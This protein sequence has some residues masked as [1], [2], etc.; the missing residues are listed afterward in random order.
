M[1][2]L[3]E[4]QGPMIKQW[5]IGSAIAHLR[6]SVSR[7]DVEQEDTARLVVASDM[8][9]ARKLARGARIA[10]RSIL[11]LNNVPE[12]V[13]MEVS[14]TH[15]ESETV[16]TR[17]VARIP[18]LEQDQ[19]FPPS[20]GPVSSMTNSSLPSM[21]SLPEARVPIIARDQG[22][23]ESSKDNIEDSS[24]LQDI[25]TDIWNSALFQETKS[26]A[27]SSFTVSQNFE[28][29][30]IF[31]TITTDETISEWP[32][33]VQAHSGRKEV[34]NTGEVADASFTVSQNIE[35]ERIFR[36][37]RNTEEVAI[38]TTEKFLDESSSRKTDTKVSDL[39]LD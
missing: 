17:F 27:P 9:E 8:V 13:F 39:D 32:Q 25:F 38:S 18:P 14:P 2:S 1:T 4:S 36:E 22:W 28:L 7:L 30:G 34:R 21:S 26:K 6:S 23:S 29:E 15:Q 5:T 35:L 12:P 24:D 19:V 31:K 10:A 11:V 37:V 20:L 16:T 33:D 3:V